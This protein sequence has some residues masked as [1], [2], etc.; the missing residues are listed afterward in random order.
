MRLVNKSKKK[1]YYATLLDRLKQ[2][3]SRM[4]HTS[5]YYQD[6]ASFDKSI[7]TMT[8]LQKLGIT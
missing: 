3:W 1:T 7:I 8:K 2:I 4:A 5:V 6:D